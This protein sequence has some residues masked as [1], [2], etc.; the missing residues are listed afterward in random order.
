[1][2]INVLNTMQQ[3]HQIIKKWEKTQEQYQRS[4]FL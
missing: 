4:Y 3:L 2:V 1:M